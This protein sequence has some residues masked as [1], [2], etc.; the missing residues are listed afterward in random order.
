[1]KIR[2]TR[3][4][5]LIRYAIYPYYLAISVIMYFFYNVGTYDLKNPEELKNYLIYLGIWLALTMIPGILL[6]FKRRRFGWF[7]WP[8]LLN[9]AGWG[10]NF[11]IKDERLMTLTNNEDLNELL[12]RLVDN[13][14]YTLFALLGLIGLIFIEV[15]RLRFKYEIDDQGIK[16][17]SGPMGASVQLIMKTQ[18]T[19][20]LM[21]RPFINFILGTG[22]LIVVTSS[23]MGA[24]DRGVIGG[25]TGSAGTKNVQ[26]GGFVG[27]INTEKEFVANPENC[28]YGVSNPKKVLEEISSIV[29]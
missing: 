5:F 23:G 9:L 24:G 4:A 10:L 15:Y 25:F 6:A 17:T 26:G 18:I 19:N 7:F 13:G 1:M 28:I 20:I 29:Q 22:H 8:A 2:P 14:M 11:L 12:I 27:A 16:I 21:K 3:R